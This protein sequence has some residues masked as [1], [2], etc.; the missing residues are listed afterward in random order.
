MHDSYMV[1]GEEKLYKD[2][3]YCAWLVWDPCPPILFAVHVPHKSQVLYLKLPYSELLIVLNM[4]NY[5]IIDI[6]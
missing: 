4:M 6:V 1:K 3:Y 2:C 5:P